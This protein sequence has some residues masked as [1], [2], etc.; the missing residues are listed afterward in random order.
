MY[1]D[2]GGFFSSHQIEM[3]DMCVRCVYTGRDWCVFTTI[4]MLAS[5]C[6]TR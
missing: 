2:V 4:E 1:R 5:L 6:L 3:H